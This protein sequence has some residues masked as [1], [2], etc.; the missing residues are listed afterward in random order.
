M[1]AGRIGIG[2]SD[3][4]LANLYAKFQKTQG[5]VLSVCKSAGENKGAMG[6]RDYAGDHETLPV[7]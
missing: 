5:A 4:V 6:P 3:K 1:F 2:F 7:A